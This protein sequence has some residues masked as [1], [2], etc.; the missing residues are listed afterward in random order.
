MDR[1]AEAG[2]PHALAIRATTRLSRLRADPASSIEDR[3]QAVDD[4][5]RAVNSGEPDALL[6]GA[7]H[8]FGNQQPAL[9]RLGVIM[10]LVACRSGG[11]CGHD[12]EIFPV[13]SCYD[14]GEAAC[15]PGSNLVDLVSQGVDPEVYA[16][17]F[18]AADQFEAQLKSGDAQSLRQWFEAL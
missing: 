13:T 17:A 16:E 4:L 5:V 2:Y 7:L 1:S 11:D 10:V 12:S 18:A 9:D 6:H 3:R 8:L 14:L 15:G